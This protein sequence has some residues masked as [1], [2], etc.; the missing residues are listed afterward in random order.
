MGRRSAYR[1]RHHGRT[2]LPGKPHRPGE[3]DVPDHRHVVHH[4][5][6]AAAHGVR[7]VRSTIG[8]R[9]HYQQ[10]F[11]FVIRL[12]R[13]DPHRRG[14]PGTRDVALLQLRVASVGY[15]T[16]RYGVPGR[17]GRAHHDLRHRRTCDLHA[18]TH[19]FLHPL[20]HAARQ[21]VKKRGAPD[22]G[23]KSRAGHGTTES[24]HVSGLPRSNLPAK[25]PLVRPGSTG[26]TAY[27]TSPEQ[28]PDKQPPIR[29]P[30]Q[31]T[32]RQSASQPATW[33]TGRPENKNAVRIFAPHLLFTI[34]IRSSPYFLHIRSSSA[35]SCRR[36]LRHISPSLSERGRP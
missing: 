31:Q 29:P 2:R 36:H 3:P 6:A 17:T 1:R 28:V 35:I 18:R 15:R 12:G 33:P 14:C 27:K 16:A 34:K 21:A 32:A 9:G 5:G 24:N 20:G 25:R 22:K 13:T 30:R 7:L 10:R 23:N 4:L 8:H 26:A 19:G 11:Q